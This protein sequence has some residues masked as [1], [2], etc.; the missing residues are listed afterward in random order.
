ML[1][2][3]TISIITF[4]SVSCQTNTQVE[5]DKQ[6]LYNEKEMPVKVAGE[7][8][9][10][11]GPASDKEGNVYFTDQ[12]HNKIYVYTV[13]GVLK[14]FTDSSGRSNGLYFSP[15][16]ILYAC[17]DMDN[18][19]W[20]FNETGQ[21]EVVLE[22]IDS[23]AFNGPNDL[24]INSEG[25]IYF[26]DPYY[27]RDYWE[28]EHPENPV[29][30]VY[31]LAPGSESPVLVADGFKRPNGIVGNEKE[32][33]LYVSDI[34]LDSTYQF[35]IRDNKLLGERRYFT[36]MT[37]DGMTLD[38]SGNLYLTG[39]GVTIFSKEGKKLAHIPIDENWTGNVCFGGK[40]HKT[41]FIT[42]STGLYTLQMNVKGL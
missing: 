18:E 16:G 38:E 25:G 26:T 40:D 20:K 9:F 13:D 37:S 5:D 41:L 28:G 34:D 30:G 15:D 2:Y 36:D 4:W 10:T 39:K 17:A 12:P 42:A 33:T 7:F 11:E 31:Y 29:K 1:K 6:S 8:V 19:L 23:I 24:W 35:E 21:A 22:G 27:K 3:V 32:G 14:E